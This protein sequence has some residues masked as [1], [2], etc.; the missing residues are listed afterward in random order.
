MSAW[1]IDR[2][3]DEQ[4][5]TFVPCT[6]MG[7]VVR[8]RARAINCTPTPPTPRARGLNSGLL[9]IKRTAHA[10]AMQKIHTARSPD[11]SAR[12]ITA[13]AGRGTPG[14]AR[15]AHGAQSSRRPTRSRRSGFVRVRAIA[16]D[17]Q[18]VR[19]RV[20]APA[21]RRAPVGPLRG[22]PSETY[23]AAAR[24]GAVAEADEER[25]G[26]DARGADEA[27][28]GLDLSFGSRRRARAR[29]PG[30]VHRTACLNLARSRRTTCAPPI[31]VQ[32]RPNPAAAPIRF[33]HP[34]L[35]ALVL[36]RVCAV[37]GEACR[38]AGW[39][40]QTGPGGGVSH[41]S[42]APALADTVPSSRPASCQARAF[43]LRRV[44]AGADRH[45]DEGRTD[46]RGRAWGKGGRV[47]GNGRLSALASIE[48]TAV[49]RTEPFDCR[50][51]VR[52]AGI[53]GRT[54]LD[55]QQRAEE[56]EIQQRA[57]ECSARAVAARRLKMHIA[58]G[59]AA[60]ETIRTGMGWPIEAPGHSPIR[61]SAC[62]ST[63]KPATWVNNQHR[64]A[65]I[66]DPRLPP[67]LVSILWGQWARLALKTQR[68][69]RAK[70]QN[71]L[72]GYSR[73]GV[74]RYPL[75]ARDRDFGNG[76]H[77]GKVRNDTRGGSRLRKTGSL[78][79]P[80]GRNAS[81]LSSFLPCRL[82]NVARPIPF[83]IDEGVGMPAALLCGNIWM[84]GAFLCPWNPISRSI[85][86]SGFRQPHAGPVSERR[87]Y[88]QSPAP[89]LSAL[90]F[91][92]PIHISKSIEIRQNAQGLPST[93]QHN[94]APRTKSGTRSGGDRRL[95][96]P[97][98]K[99]WV[100]I[101]QTLEG[102]GIAVAARSE[103]LTPL[104]PR[105]HMWLAPPNT[106]ADLE[107]RHCVGLRDFVRR[108]ATPVSGFCIVVIKLPFPGTIR[109][110]S[111][112]ISR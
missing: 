80:R 28:C 26:A 49:M 66:L 1:T 10:Q 12:T 57:D 60:S 11:A 24:G 76:S 68:K 104:R 77:L 40:G 38:R 87:S 88:T 45:H 37:R 62:K 36:M 2:A 79:S 102:L 84:Q 108:G 52:E 67:H 47:N 50:A 64:S 5:M 63:R 83:L 75:C 55:N 39:L 13:T 72:A 61:R 19:L 43:S 109:I 107:L 86:P 42:A 23:A 9:D 105:L 73:R 106:D 111:D 54:D 33:A 98:S 29:S 93:I 46:C 4:E 22:V 89:I 90:S 17:R 101:N 81:S 71:A 78:P 8:R 96:S 30:A 16:T 34:T 110:K 58:G 69:V 41:P 56:Q 97:P 70:S 3:A 20:R 82:T 74:P 100:G 15:N 95:R 27:L 48:C 18:R 53:T 21:V 31:G 92:H 59:G 91:I 35:A 94:Q 51:G 65:D 14:E 25:V 85:S 6:S 99:N 103:E 32:P 112:H 7:E 44:Q